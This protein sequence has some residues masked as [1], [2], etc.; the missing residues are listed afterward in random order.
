MVADEFSKLKSPSA[1]I[2]E[3]KHVVDVLADTPT[4]SRVE[5]DAKV[6]ASPSTV[7]ASALQP[8]VSDQADNEEEEELD[9]DWGEEV[10][11]DWG[12][13]VK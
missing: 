1:P 12:D 10:D 6:S 5:E 8:A 3:T 11:E 13:D 9:E 7:S 2:T 4:V